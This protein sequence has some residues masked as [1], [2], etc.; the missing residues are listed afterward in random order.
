MLDTHHNNLEQL[1]ELGPFTTSAVAEPS[2]D[3][4]SAFWTSWSEGDGQLLFRMKDTGT[5]DQNA[6][7]NFTCTGFSL[8]VTYLIP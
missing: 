4:G 1:S 6:Y 2:V 8:V 3:I 7:A 5:P